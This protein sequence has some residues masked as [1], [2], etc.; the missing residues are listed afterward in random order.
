M[1]RF[2]MMWSRSRE[3]SD[4]DDGEDEDEEQGGAYADRAESSYDVMWVALTS[5]TDI[6]RCDQGSLLVARHLF[7]VRTGH[8]G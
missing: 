4:W 8:C 1:V 5:W 2:V 7:D 6:D 3:E